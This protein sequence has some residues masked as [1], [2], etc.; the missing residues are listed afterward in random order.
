MEVQDLHEAILRVAGQLSAK[1]TCDLQDGQA[2]KLVEAIN[3]KVLSAKNSTGKSIGPSARISF[4][5]SL[6]P[7]RRLCPSCGSGFILL[8][9][10]LIK[11]LFRSGRIYSPQA[12]PCHGCPGSLGYVDLCNH[13]DGTA[14][15]T[16]DWRG[17][18]GFHRR[19]SP[20]EDPKASLYQTLLQ[21][22][23]FRAAVPVLHGRRSI[24]NV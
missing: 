20:P 5:P 13:C 12:H 21:D 7:C 23:G 17:N 10:S 9:C 2:E 3:S 16:T 19:T 4:C 22:H 24:S 18:V 14:C 6:I 1:E 11:I 8:E 15:P